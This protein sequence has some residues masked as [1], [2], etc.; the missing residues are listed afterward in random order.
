MKTSPW[1]KHLKKLPRDY[2]LRVDI[3]SVDK[4]SCSSIAED[5]GEVL[6]ATLFREPPEDGWPDKH[7]TPWEFDDKVV[8]CITTDPDDSITFVKLLNSMLHE[9]VKRTK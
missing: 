4:P 3:E 7:G 1:L 2:Y 9:E 8:V 5:E 6:T